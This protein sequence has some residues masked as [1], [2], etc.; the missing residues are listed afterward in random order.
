MRNL[1]LDYIMFPLPIYWTFCIVLIAHYIADF[2]M[3]TEWTVLNK[4]KNHRALFMHGTTY[5]LLITAAVTPLLGVE[6]ATK[7][8]LSNGALHYSTDFIFSRV[9][10]HYR[11]TLQPRKMFMAIG[12]DQLIHQIT[13][14]VT[15]FWVF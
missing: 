2:P 4:Y 3:Q 9:T 7:Y 12:L 6:D 10:A 1:F 5:T 11:A 14:A 15:L 8:G 13:L